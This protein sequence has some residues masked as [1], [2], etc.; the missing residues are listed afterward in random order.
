MKSKLLAGVFVFLV[1]LLFLNPAA[2]GQGVGTS[3]T[4]SGT[5]T[6]PQGGVLPKANIVA[7]ETARGTQSSGVTDESGQYRLTGLLP[8]SYRV[9][10]HVDR[11]ETEAMTDVVV[12]IGETV[13]LD[14]HLKLATTSQTVEVT[15][16]PPV[17][18]TE[19]GSQANTITQ[20]YIEDL[21]ID[22][23]DYL[24]F[25][26]L[27]PG[28]SDST[29]L[30]DDQRRPTDSWPG[31]SPRVPSEPQQLC[32]GLGRRKWSIDQHCVEIRHERHSRQLI[33]LFPK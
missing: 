32:S 23:R 31:C 29:R 7:T 9:T 15:A 6:D 5:V 33:R 19:R 26:L 24:T 2:Y 11:F 1:C 20:Q 3:G 17:V 25:T 10:T 12:N 8:G 18:E 14:F 27:L 30:A 13:I 22:R 21:P 4:I 16:I 28:V